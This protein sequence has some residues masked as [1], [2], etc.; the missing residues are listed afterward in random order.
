MLEGIVVAGF[1]LGALV[2]LYYY[3]RPAEEVVA[4]PASPLAAKVPT[5]GAREKAYTPAPYSAPPVHVAPPLDMTVLFVAATLDTSEP[6][7]YSSPN[8]YGGDAG[9]SYSDTSTPTNTYD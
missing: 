2:L 9:T 4:E 5:W 7:R 1:L 8:A 6:E 3:N